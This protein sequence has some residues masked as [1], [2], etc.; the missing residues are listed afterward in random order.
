M[1]SAPTPDFGGYVHPDDDRLAA[2]RRVYERHL[3]VDDIYPGLAQRIIE[4]GAHVWAIR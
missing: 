3:V 2:W 1:T 4:H